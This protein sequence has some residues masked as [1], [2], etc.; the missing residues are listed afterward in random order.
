MAF[1]TILSY[2]AS[3]DLEII[4]EYYYELN[5]NT[6]KKYYKNIL[7]NVK[8][9]RDFPKIGRIVPE[10]EDIF[11]DKYREI[12]YGNF[13]IIYKI[14]ENTIVVVRIIDGRRLLK[15]DMVEPEWNPKE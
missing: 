2:A 3:T 14:V 11:Y 4:V 15:L 5:K 12:N 1:K 7:N 13:R 10:F 6:A 9:L 8:R